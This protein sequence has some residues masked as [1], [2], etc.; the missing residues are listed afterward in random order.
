MH[1][2][3]LERSCLNVVVSILITTLVTSA[4]TESTTE[5]GIGSRLGVCRCGREVQPPSNVLAFAV[6]GRESAQT[7]VGSLASH[8]CRAAVHILR[9]DCRAAN[10]K[11]TLDSVPVGRR[12]RCLHWYCSKSGSWIKTSRDVVA[13]P[14]LPSSHNC[15]RKYPDVTH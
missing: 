7:V 6:G 10:G 3:F 1:V 15:W 12:R 9:R 5:P 2:L 13:A 14:A 11:R 8:C 4:N